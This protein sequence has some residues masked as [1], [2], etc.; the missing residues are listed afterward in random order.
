M[1]KIHSE[2]PDKSATDDNALM[3]PSGPGSSL[4]RLYQRALDALLSIGPFAAVITAYG[5][6]FDNIPD[7][8]FSYLV[9]KYIFSGVSALAVGLVLRLAAQHF[10]SSRGASASGPDQP[11][12]PSGRHPILAVNFSRP[13]TVLAQTAAAIDADLRVGEHSNTPTYGWSQYIGDKVPPSAIGTSYGLRTAML[14]DIRST[15]INYGRIV[16]S[17]L[18]LQRP[19]GGWAASTQRGIARPEVTAWILPPAMRAGMDLHIAQHL[20]HHLEGMS[21]GNGTMGRNQ[22]G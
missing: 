11:K 1:L 7:Q 2:P 12:V 3:G 21:V 13:N 22:C 6:I 18:T 19:G 17:L 5:L 16:G 15:R 9:L 14:L 20:I 8:W 4:Q 10:R